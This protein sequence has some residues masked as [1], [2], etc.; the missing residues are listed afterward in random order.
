M[1][2]GGR[3]E[4]SCQ[5]ACVRRD[6][7]PE[8]TVKDPLDETKVRPQVPRKQWVQPTGSVVET[9]W[10]GGQELEPL[11]RF[12]ANGLARRNPHFFSGSRITAD[13]GFSRPDAENS[14]ASQLEPFPASHG[15]LHRFEDR[16]DGHLRPRLAQAGAVNDVRDNVE[17]D[18]SW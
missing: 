11:A 3:C 16:L 7:T 9:G 12:E 8:G 4:T 13:A 15:P 2:A 1:S 5:I 14:E 17:L 6:S 18:H 10:W